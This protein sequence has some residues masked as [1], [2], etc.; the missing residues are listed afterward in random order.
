MSFWI[1][2]IFYLEHLGNL[3]RISE[4][5]RKPEFLTSNSKFSSKEL[6][7]IK[8]LAHKCFPTIKKKNKDRLADRITLKIF[9]IA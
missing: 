3:R 2:V 6:L 4:G 7:A 5:V 1:W 9:L 8:V